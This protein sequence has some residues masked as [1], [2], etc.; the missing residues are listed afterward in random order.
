MVCGHVTLFSIA[1]TG[2]KILNHSQI[3]RSKRRGRCGR[4]SGGWGGWGIGMLDTSTMADPFFG[5]RGIGL[6]LLLRSVDR[7][8]L[9]CGRRCCHWGVDSVGSGS[10]AGGITQC[11]SWCR[12]RG[13]FGGLHPYAPHKNYLWRLCIAIVWGGWSWSSSVQTIF[14]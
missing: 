11:C 13:V 10:D 4:M 8:V 9:D 2:Y 5:M 6:L 12:C 14:L 3:R 1:H 7:H